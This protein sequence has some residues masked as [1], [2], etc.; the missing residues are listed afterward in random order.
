M[1]LALGRIDFVHHASLPLPFV[2]LAAGKRTLGESEAK[3]FVIN[4]DGGISQAGE[5]FAL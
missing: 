4:L 1:H 5:K 2:V 3:V